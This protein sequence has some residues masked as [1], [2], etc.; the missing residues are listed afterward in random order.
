MVIYTCQICNIKF[1]QKIDYTR[2]I[3]RKKPCN[4]NKE[5]QMGVSPPELFKVPPK[6]LQM[7]KINKKENYICF[8]CKN[9]FSNKYNC[10]RHMKLI[11]KVKKQHE[12][13]KEDKYNELIQRIEINEKNT[14][15]NNK[16]FKEE[17]NQLRNQLNEEKEK[18]NKL[19]QIIHKQT[20]K[21][22]IKNQNNNIEN[23]I[24]NVTINFNLEAF[25]RED[26]NKIDEKFIME[27][28]K[29]GIASVPVF[30]E[31]VHFDI[32]YPEFNNVYIPSTTHSHAM[33]KLF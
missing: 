23:L 31:R 16:M 15:N 3:N 12:K 6:L 30:T 24:N 18:N 5:F 21:T 4:K 7:E 20:N 17:I 29:R 9:N 14:E 10:E 26:M 28:L 13:E 1:N 8:Y 11:C 32:K 19:N 2:H 33:V 25:G 27:A 22:E